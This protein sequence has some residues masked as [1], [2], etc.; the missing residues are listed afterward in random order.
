MKVCGIYKITNPVGKIYIGQSRDIIK[1]LNGYKRGVC[2]QQTKLYHS[3]HKY[4]WDNH[5]F[6]VIEQCTI[7]QLNDQ[8]IYWINF[9]D[10]FDTDHGLNL[11]SGG[12]VGSTVSEQTRER[13]RQKKLGTHRSEETKAK[14]S[15]NNACTRR[16][17]P[18]TD[19]E[20][21]RISEKVS[22][23]LIGNQRSLGYKY[24][25]DQLAARPIPIQTEQKRKK[26]SEATKL[27]WANM[28]SE[29]RLE[30]SEKIR[31]A[32]LK[33]P[34]SGMLGKK[35]SEETK[36]KIGEANKLRALERKKIA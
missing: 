34:P 33:N 11:Q 7:L 32:N 25:S 21:K 24:T 35:Q 26:N 8:E 5:V 10:C 28:S 16:G 15:K 20:K 27:M 19:D 14:I 12:L 22:K 6:E 36:R 18:L 29:R 17:K 23:S 4:G 3:V 30:I 9:Y 13:Q 31:Q 1:R 2:K